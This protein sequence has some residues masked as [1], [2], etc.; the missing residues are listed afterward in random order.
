MEIPTWTLEDVTSRDAYEAILAR[1]GGDEL[2]SQLAAQREAGR[3]LEAT[4]SPAQRELYL[5]HSD[6]AS[7]AASLREAA[8]ARVVLC[9]GAGIGAA[10]A[11][12][13]D[14]DPS[15]LLETA[16]SVVGAVLGSELSPAEAHDV[17]A[18]VLSTLARASVELSPRGVPGGH[19][20][21]RTRRTRPTGQEAASAAEATRTEGSEEE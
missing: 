16:T 20:A 6:A 21:V 7:D 3:A 12:F 13:P 11:R 18:A 15:A 1:V 10:F 8:S 4:L 17:A 2:T 5:T 19:R 14:A 9:F